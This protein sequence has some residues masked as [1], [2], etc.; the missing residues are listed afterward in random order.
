[1][2]L[3]IEDETMSEKTDFDKTHRLL[4]FKKMLYKLSKQITPEE[5]NECFENLEPKRWGYAYRDMTS[6]YDMRIITEVVFTKVDK[7]KR[8]MEILEAEKKCLGDPRLGD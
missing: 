4:A 6:D 2:L 8:E 7:D 1:M 5:L 3:K